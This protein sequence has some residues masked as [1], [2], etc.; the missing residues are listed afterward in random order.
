MP[1]LL[2]IS[3]VING[4]S[5]RIRSSTSCSRSVNI[6]SRRFGALPRMSTIR[7]SNS[8]RISRGAGNSSRSSPIV[9]LKNFRIFVALTR[10]TV[11]RAIAESASFL[12]AST[13]RLT[14]RVRGYFLMSIGS[15]LDPFCAVGHKPDAHGHLLPGA[16][17]K[18]L[19]KRLQ[20]GDKPRSAC[21]CVC[22]DLQSFRPG[23]PRRAS[24][25][26]KIS[27]SPAGPLDRWPAVL[28]VFAHSTLLYALL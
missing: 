9:S 17:C 27:P 18:Q 20:S 26:L 19:L 15:P 12:A 7:A 21:C 8:R 22:H 11:R 3:F 4:P 25:R 2:A 23:R 24:G 16:G 1:M 5:A 6:A 14:S 13:A 10:G 28:P